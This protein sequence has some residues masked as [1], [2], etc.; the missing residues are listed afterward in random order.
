MDGCRRRG[1]RCRSVGGPPGLILGAVLLLTASAAR[2]AAQAPLTLPS[3]SHPAIVALLHEGKA[4]QGLAA[5]DLDYANRAPDA[6]PVHA[7]ALRAALLQAANRGGEA[8]STWSAVAAVEPALSDFAGRSAVESLIGSNQ[9]ARAEARL[10]DLASGRPARVQPGLTIEVADAFR[11]S[12]QPG[13]AIRLYRQV[14]AAGSQRSARVDAALLG[15]AAA[16][17]VAGN[18]DDALEQ[19][20]RAQIRHQD[21]STFITARTEARRLAAARGQRPRTFTAVEYRT[22]S[23]RLGDAS[24]F[25]EAVELLEEWL[26][27][28]GAAS[29]A[30]I[31]ASIVDML[32]RGR[33]N[34]AAMAR[35]DAFIRRFP[36]NRRVPAIKLLQFRLDVREGRTEQV[37]TRGYELWRG[38]VRG[39]SRSQ[40]RSAGLLLGAYLVSVGDVKSG[41][42]VYRELYR[43]STTQN[44]RRD[45]LWRAGVAALRD[46]QVD[47]AATN[48]RALIRLRPSGQLRLLGDYWLGVAEARAGNRRAAGDAWRNLIQ[49]APYS[50]YGIKAASAYS[51]LLGSAGVADQVAQLLRPRER[52]PALSLSAAAQTDRRYRAAVALA[53]AGLSEPAAALARELS[54]AFRRD[55]AVGLLAARASALAGEH[56]QAV[57]LVDRHFRSFLDRP[58]DGLPDDLEALAF[59]RA[60]WDEIQPAA[61]REDVDPLLLQSIM[62]QESRYQAPVR[63]AAGAV[64]LFQLMSYTAEALAPSLGMEPPDEQALKQPSVSAA[65]GARLV[66]NLMRMFDGATAPTAA[67]YNAGEDLAAVWWREADGLPEEMF[68]DSVPYSETR[69]Y[70]RLVLANYYTYQRLYGSGN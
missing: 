55:K 27:R 10:T 64:G 63:S 12:G 65:F 16:L 30:E 29:V 23:S 48:L 17:E 44:Q 61:S 40:Q 36:A 2:V 69:N 34:D 67:S 11:R 24:R 13:P 50:Y 18:D 49:R 37:R 33:Q 56:H 43:A 38:R 41:L 45:I 26:S 14:I 7:L 53:R 51:R 4:D 1:G 9:P 59:P 60:Y 46:G 42:A 19:L 5:L 3:P 20:H 54:A 21:S 25:A 32:Y 58:A 62:R 22:L 39:A 35:A 28:S 47:R 6:W 57:R 68:V 31:E 15:L 70:I 52:F 8:A 66:G